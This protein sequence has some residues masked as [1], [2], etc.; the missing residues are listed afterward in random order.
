MLELIK[1]YFEKFDD[2]VPMQQ[3]RGYT[4]S[5]IRKMVEKS[6]KTGLP[7]VPEVI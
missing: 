1:A 5:E 7:I 6:L 2:V 3:L 4:D